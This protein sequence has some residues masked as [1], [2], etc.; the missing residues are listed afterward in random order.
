MRREFEHIRSVEDLLRL[1]EGVL[2]GLVANVFRDYGY[3][4]TAASGPRSYG[5]DVVMTKDGQKVVVQV[6]QYEEAAGTDDVRDAHFAKHYYGADEAWMVSARGFAEQAVVAAEEVG[7]HLVTGEGVLRLMEGCTFEEG[8]PADEPAAPE[9]HPST[10]ALVSFAT[11]PEM[12]DGPTHE[13]R[14]LKFDTNRYGDP[15]GF[16]WGFLVVD[17]GVPGLNSLSGEAVDGGGVRFWAE[18]NDGCE[19][20]YYAVRKADQGS[21]SASIVEGHLEPKDDERGASDPFRREIGPIKT[22]FSVYLCNCH[23]IPSPGIDGAK[24]A[25]V[26]EGYRRRV[27]PLADEFWRVNGDQ[28]DRGKL[29]RKD[30]LAALDGLHDKI[31][32][33]NVQFVAKAQQVGLDHGYYIRRYGGS[34]GNELAPSVQAARAKETARLAKA[35]RRSQ[36]SGE[37]MGCLA[38]GCLKG[39]YFLIMAAFAIMMLV[40]YLMILFI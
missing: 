1:D 20:G 40:G 3:V 34:I 22:G 26:E 18:L 5:A 6:R 37:L 31:R 28:S 27:T 17:R 35:K 16:L 39:C 7:V 38:E 12:F 14:A 23:L 13:L 15:P 24:A 29:R 25:R 33:T 2:R 10:M 4:V 30:K 8:E 9:E 19:R 32:S 21:E 36:S 11:Y